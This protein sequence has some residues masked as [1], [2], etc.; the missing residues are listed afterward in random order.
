MIWIIYI[1]IAFLTFILLAKDSLTVYSFGSLIFCLFVSLVWPIF[2][3]VE[4]LFLI[5][6][7]FKYILK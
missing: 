1:T 7:V 5:W 3:T 6:I 2:W 4:V